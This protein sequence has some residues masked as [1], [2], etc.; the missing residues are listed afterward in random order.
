MKPCTP[1]RTCKVQHLIT[2]GSPLALPHA[3]FDRLLPAPCPRGA[4]PANTGRWTNIAD[5]GDVV[6]VPP[7]GVRDRFDGVDQDVETAIHVADFHL[8]QRYLK[9][10][11]MAE[12][13]RHSLGDVPQTG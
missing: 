5:V 13:L 3:V 2:L 1:T 4:R 6:A 7:R 9:T 8:A 10:A 11:A 12:A